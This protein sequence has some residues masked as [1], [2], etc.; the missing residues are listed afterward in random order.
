MVTLTPV[1]EKKAIKSFSLSEEAQSRSRLKGEPVGEGPWPKFA[2]T[3]CDLLGTIIPS[4]AIEDSKMASGWA[5][6]QLQTQNVW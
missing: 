2:R 5:V 6:L 4:S 3:P 1:G